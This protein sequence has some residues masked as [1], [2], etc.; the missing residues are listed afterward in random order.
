MIPIRH[1]FLLYTLLIII[2]KYTLYDTEI[3]YDFLNNDISNLKYMA[4]SF[5]QIVKLY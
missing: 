1:I 5:N 3:F 2:I 4:E